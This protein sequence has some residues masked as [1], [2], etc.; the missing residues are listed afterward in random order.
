MKAF[1]GI[2]AAVVL[3][4]FAAML[5]FEDEMGS[6]LSGERK[7]T[8]SC[9]SSVIYNLEH[10]KP[11]VVTRDSRCPDDVAMRWEIREN[12]APVL[13][14][15]ELASNEI[16]TYTMLPNNPSPQAH[17]LVMRVTFLAVAPGDIRV[18]YE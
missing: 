17:A 12:S 16:R 1:A 3:L 11:F 6:F 2:L 18:F 14:A 10:D 13:V 4:A 8:T 15:M 9:P 5:L 7:I